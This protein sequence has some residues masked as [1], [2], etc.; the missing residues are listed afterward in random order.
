MPK[1]TAFNPKTDNQPYITTQLNDVRKVVASYSPQVTKVSVVPSSIVEQQ[2]KKLDSAGIISDTPLVYPS[3]SY[4]SGDVDATK[5]LDTLSSGNNTIDR[6]T[7]K[8]KETIIKTQ[9][10]FKDITTFPKLPD[11][12]GIF[13]Q[14]GKFGQYALIGLGGLIIF[15]LTRR[16]A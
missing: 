11:M 4:D 8:D 13:E 15:N 14:I 5:G 2:Q 7:I 9:E 16:S 3:G 12:T 1:I 6:I 10:F